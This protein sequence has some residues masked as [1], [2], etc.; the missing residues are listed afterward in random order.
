MRMIRRPLF[1][2]SKQTKK[3]AMGNS[4]GAK[5]CHITCRVQNTNI[6][7]AVRVGAAH[8]GTAGRG[9]DGLHRTPTGRLAKE[10]TVSVT[11]QIVRVLLDARTSE[12]LFKPMGKQNQRFTPGTAAALRPW[13]LTSVPTLI[14][15]CIPLSCKAY[16]E[17][18]VCFNLETYQAG[19][20]VASRPR[21]LCR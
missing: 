19:T 21:D 2:I 1:A 5:R 10:A 3:A 9:R 4:A 18:C 7:Q 20:R 16:A 12:F 15:G 17:I 13:L 11:L 6:P 8:G 14:C